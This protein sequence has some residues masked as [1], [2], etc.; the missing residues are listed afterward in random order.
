[1]NEISFFYNVGIPEESGAADMMEFIV[2]EKNIR[3]VIRSRQ[4]MSAT[5]NDGI[6]YRIIKAAGQEGVT[7]MKLIIEGTIRY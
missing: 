3:E 2:S 6:G 4:D 1:M 7:L 5:G